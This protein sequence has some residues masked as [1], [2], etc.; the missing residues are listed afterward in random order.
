MRRDVLTMAVVC[1]IIA[2]ALGEDFDLSWHSIDGGGVIK[3]TGGDFELSGTIGQPDAGLL[4]GGDFELSGGFWFKV[5][6]SDCN[7]DGVVDLF[8]VVLGGGH[9]SSITVRRRW[10]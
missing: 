9:R 2:P 5:V 8:D 7:D 6:P 4:T 10:L 3:S 1:W